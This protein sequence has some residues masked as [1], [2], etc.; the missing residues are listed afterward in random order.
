MEI[1]NLLIFALVGAV[2]MVIVT[3]G[4]ISMTSEK[5]PDTSSLGA[6]AAMGGGLGLAASYLMQGDMSKMI[7][8]SIDSITSSLGGTDGPDM[9]V[10]LPSF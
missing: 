10:G 7:G 9:K 3:G 8:G 6:G 1:Q 2:C 4:F 5:E